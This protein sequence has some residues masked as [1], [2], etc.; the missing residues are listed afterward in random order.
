VSGNY[1]DSAFCWATISYFDAAGAARWAGAMDVE[2]IAAVKARDKRDVQVFTP[3]PITRGRDFSRRVRE[4]L[5]A[6]LRN[7]R[8]WMRR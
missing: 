3:Q 8:S 7:L 1:G 2:Q 4:L 6:A 5:S